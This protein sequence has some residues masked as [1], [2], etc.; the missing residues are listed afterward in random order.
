MKKAIFILAIILIFGLVFGIET[1]TL[2]LT[3]D[4]IK[5]VKW[6]DA[7]LELAGKISYGFPD[8]SL[9]TIRPLTIKTT[10]DTTKAWFV[11]SEKGIYPAPL[12]V[13]EGYIVTER[14]TISES[15][16][17]LDANKEEIKDTIWDYRILKEE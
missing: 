10:T 6:T 8:D 9:I 13:I 4:S 2:V 15:Y 11:V 1:K 14:Y 5:T 16:K 12:Y 7:I 3:P 17:C